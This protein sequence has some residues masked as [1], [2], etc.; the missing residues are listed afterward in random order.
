MIKNHLLYFSLFWA[1]GL[2]AQIDEEIPVPPLVVE[3]PMARGKT[4]FGG[5]RTG[6]PQ[7]VNQGGKTG[8]ALDDS[9]LVP[10][11]YYKMPNVYND[12]MVVHNYEGYW[13]VIDKRGRIV[14]PFEY[15]QGGQLYVWRPS[16]PSSFLSKN[17][18]Q[19]YF[20]QQGNALFETRF[21]ALDVEATNRLGVKHSGWLVVTKI[22]TALGEVSAI[23]DYAGNLLFPFKYYRIA[24]ATPQRVGVAEGRAGK[25]GVCDWQGREIIPLVYQELAAPDVNGHLTAALTPDQ[26]GLLDTAGRVLIP[27]EYQTCSHNYQANAFYDLKKGE[28]YGLADRNGKLVIAP[29]ARHKPTPV[30][31]SSMRWERDGPGL[32]LSRS[33]RTRGRY[34]MQRVSEQELA[35]YHGDRG[36]LFRGD[37]T[38]VQPLN[39]EGP[40]L[41]YMK[42]GMQRLYNLDGRDL[43]GGDHSAIIPNE[44]QTCLYVKTGQNQAHIYAP[45]G[46]RI[47]EGEFKLSSLENLPKGFFV[48]TDT[49]DRYALFDPY[50]KR[51]TEH[52]FIGIRRPDAEAGTKARQKGT[53]KAGR[54]IV[55]RGMIEAPAEGTTRYVNID[56][57]GEIVD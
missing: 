57:T 44:F 46:S 11:Q 48:L 16:D 20:N 30:Q 22:D 54:T 26:Q 52:R 13:G 17:G 51:L 35:L 21:E 18:R 23:A 15:E 42:N 4:R 3:E 32:R 1:S 31:Y 34:W 45:D 47:V 28:F 24:W 19:Q 10:I 27:L 38:H 5:Y 9:L 39:D 8:W 2:S 12:F 53:L 25:T 55:A 6:T 43:L 7:H 29:A 50:G 14:K 49:T 36:L 56:N 41:V 40:V 37:F 33:E